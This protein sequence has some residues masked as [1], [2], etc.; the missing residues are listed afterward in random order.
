MCGSSDP[1]L[2]WVT[3][4]PCCPG[5]VCYEDPASPVAGDKFCMETEPIPV[6]GNCRVRP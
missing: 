3:L 1:A 4:L 2:A 5:L 6:G